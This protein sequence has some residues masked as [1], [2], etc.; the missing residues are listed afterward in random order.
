MSMTM[1]CKVCG[2]S[3]DE[4]EDEFGN[5]AEITDHQ[6]IKKCTKCIREYNAETGDDRDDE[7][8]EDSDWKDQIMA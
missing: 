3:K 6:G 8:L 1:K 2:R 4:L 7:E 5:K